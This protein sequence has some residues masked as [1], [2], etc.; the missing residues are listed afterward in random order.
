MCS[1][2]DDEMKM[3]TKQAMMNLFGIYSTGGISPC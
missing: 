3:M 1:V 2:I